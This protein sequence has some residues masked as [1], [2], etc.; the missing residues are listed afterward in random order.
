MEDK[1][2]LLQKHFLENV[3]SKTLGY[4]IGFAQYFLMEGEVKEKSSHAFCSRVKNTA[5]P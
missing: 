5:L 4:F 3:V 2:T 1:V